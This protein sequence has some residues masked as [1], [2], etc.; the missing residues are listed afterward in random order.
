MENFFSLWKVR[1]LADK[2]TNV[3]MNYTD[4]EAKVREATNDEAWGP[5]GQIMQDLAHA[6]FTYEHFP[7]VM[8]ML[9]KRM[10]QDNKQHWRRTYKSLLV[11]NYLIKNGSERVVTSAR[12]HIYDLRSLENY[13]FID[14]YGKDQGVNVRHKVKELIDFIQDDDKLREERKK[15][16]KNKDKYIGM[17]SDMIGSSFSTE[18]WD[19]HSSSRDYADQ[20][21]I[22]N[23]ST[24]KQYKD[25]SYEDDYE[26]EL[27]ESDNESNNSKKYKD[28]DSTTIGS[29]KHGD[30]KVNLTINTSLTKSPAK[31]AVKQVKKVDLGAAATFGVNDKGEKTPP[32]SDLLND[33]DFNPRAAESAEPKQ[34]PEFGDFETAFGNQVNVG[35]KDEDDFADFSS[36]FN[37]PSNANN[38]NVLATPPSPLLHITQSPQLI[39][40]PSLQQQQPLVIGQSGG[41]PMS[42]TPQQQGQSDLL[43]D[44]SGFNSLSV[45]PNMNNENNL[46]S[47]NLQSN[48]NNSN[49]IFDMFDAERAVPKV[50]EDTVRMDTL[51]P[52]NTEE[53][54]SFHTTPLNGAVRTLEVTLGKRKKI[55]SSNDIKLIL[56]QIDVVLGCLRE[57]RFDNGKILLEDSSEGHRKFV[58]VDYPLILNELVQRFDSRFP[59]DENGKIYRSVIDIFLIP[60][61]YFSSEAFN[62]LID[63]FAGRDK[64]KQSISAELLEHLLSS[65]SFF[66][67]LL[68]FYIVTR[69]GII[70]E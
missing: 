24:V 68:L 70:K 56:E 30:K 2:V 23:N 39:R 46:N 59:L 53:T 31:T 60:D 6:T 44:L 35:K 17:S 13:T 1:E 69:R 67:M 52:Q 5:T 42:V 33:S 61:R 58:S 22:D 28:S 27:E 21:D 43:G 10:L 50:K 8:S 34:G 49:N 47:N 37:A 14:D 57:Y 7:E 32:P 38:A 12:E 20:R 62:V 25:R 65:E 48:V 3:V 26:G 4:V 36:A 41:V 63:G 51:T 11:L 29:P 9:W 18:R 66:E 54:S 64:F 45:Q 55:S 40:Q 16:K 15:A 19:D